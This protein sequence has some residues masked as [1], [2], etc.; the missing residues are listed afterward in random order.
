MSNALAA[1]FINKSESF[2]DY[3]I[4]KLHSVHRS[5]YMIGRELTTLEI[6][7]ALI[8]CLK[9]LSEEHGDLLIN[10]VENFPDPPSTS[11]DHTDHPSL[12]S[13][14]SRLD[15]TSARDRAMARVIKID[16]NGHLSPQVSYLLDL[17]MDLDSIQKIAR[18]FP[19]FTYYS[20]DRKIKPV[21]DLLLDLGVSKQD[22]P[23][24][25]QRRPQLCG[26]SFSENL[27]PSM[28]YLESFGVDKTQWAK[29]ITTVPALLT[30]SRQKIKSFI[31]FLLTLGVPE[32]NIGKIL[33]RRPGI[34][35]YS[36]EEKLRPV[37]EYFASLGIDVASLFHKCPQSFSLSIEA[38]LKPVTDFFYKRGFSMEEI[39]M[40]VNK[41]GALY[42][43]S[44]EGN[45]VPKWEYFLTTGYPR[46]ELV[47]FPHYFSY[48][49]EKR[50]KPRFN[51]VMECGLSLGLNRMLSTA[52][53]KFEDMLEKQMKKLA[54][55]NSKS[56]DILEKEKKLGR[57]AK[58]IEK[59]QQII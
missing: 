47:K 49:L 25:L 50:I 14:S 12:P 3:L 45:L 20:L 9:S 41:Y 56:E 7:S 43:L 4:S 48:D 39:G 32:G 29:I 22:I 1:R 44:L 26:I 36:V 37:S 15:Q 51:R 6:R 23:K 24:I 17:G 8:S 57:S 34:L 10:M 40:M 18:K 31:I 53:S 38:N 2:I 35:C 58:Y 42:T 13:P 19:S 46:S 59:E 16:E 21:V 28:L 27:K 5:H 33:T 11:S 52:N 55:A 30:Y 54:T